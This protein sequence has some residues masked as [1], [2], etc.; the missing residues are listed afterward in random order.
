MIKA[1]K[2]KFDDKVVYEYPVIKGNKSYIKP[3]D[4]LPIGEKTFDLEA[5][6]K[7]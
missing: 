3:E 4:L 1:T 5:Y 6:A 2:S 7:S